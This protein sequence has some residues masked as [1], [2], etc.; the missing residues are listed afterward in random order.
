MQLVWTREAL[1]RLI[2]IEDY[3]AE[4]SPQRAEE[5]IYQLIKQA[6]RIANFP[7]AGRVVP[8]FSIEDIREILYKNYRIVYRIKEDRI[9]VLTVFEGH[10]LL[11]KDEIL[12]KDK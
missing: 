12:D 7:Y 9:E 6:Q 1:L 8:E 3:I 2:E 4:D 10:R 11:N 5:F